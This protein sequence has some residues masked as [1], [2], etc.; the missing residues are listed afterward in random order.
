MLV[1]AALIISVS[2]ATAEN[3]V[4]T[5]NNA[6]TFKVFVTALKKSGLAETLQNAGPYTVFA[7]SDEAFAK[8]PPGTLNALMKD[9]EKLNRVLSY[10][11]IQGKVLVTEIKP[12]KTNTIQGEP[13]TLTSDNGK[14][15]VN[16]ANV[17]QSDLQADNGIIHEIDAVIMPQS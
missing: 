2:A 10:H 8:L 16:G 4:D 6:R 7:P 12:G 11:V 1:G 13:L 3:I 15:T 9:K 17:T 14:V 5:A